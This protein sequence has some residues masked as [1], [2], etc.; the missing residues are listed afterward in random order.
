GGGPLRPR[1]APAYSGAAGTSFRLGLVH[2][3][4]R[5]F[6]PAG[7]R[8]P[9]CEG[10]VGVDSLVDTWSK[11]EHPLPVQTRPLFERDLAHVLCDDRLLAQAI[12]TQAGQ[13]EWPRSVESPWARSFSSVTSR[14]TRRRPISRRCSP[15]SGPASPRRSSPTAPLGGRGA[16]ASW[17]WPLPAMRR[18]R[19][20]SST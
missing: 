18:R 11:K 5:G 19:S 13:R 12:V 10:R 3:S 1:R 7:H 16:L 9:I 8:D 14:S 2:V 4:G 17:R 15:R 6:S 20:R